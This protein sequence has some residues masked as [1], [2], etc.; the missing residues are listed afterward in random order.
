[1]PATDNTGVV[2]TSALTWSN[3]QFTNLSVDSTLIVRAAI[4]LADSDVLRMGSSDDWAIWYNGSTNK[5]QVEIEA[6][7]LGIQYTNNGTE[8]SY[9][10][11]STGTFTAKQVSASNGIMVNSATVSEN[12]S[13]PS[14]S[15][16]MS[17]G[18]MTVADGITV[19]IPSGNTWI[20]V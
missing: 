4:D 15:N 17:A 16:A 18:P 11:K 5:A 20:I 14:G 3:G 7:C 13:I 9:L 8:I 6:A 19:T 10:E 2:G 12:Y 1:L